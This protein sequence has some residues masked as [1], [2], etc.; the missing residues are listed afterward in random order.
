MAPPCAANMS[1]AVQQISRVSC[2]QARK[3]VNMGITVCHVST[4]FV[5]PRSNMLRYHSIPVL[6]TVVFCPRPFTKAVCHVT[7][8]VIALRK[9]GFAAQV[10]Y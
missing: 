9:T 2:F 7:G 8:L 3:W 10:I 4:K 6:F 5:P 1:T